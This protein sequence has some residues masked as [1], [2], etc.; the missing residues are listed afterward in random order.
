MVVRR[1]TLPG[2]DLLERRL[3]AGGLARS[4]QARDFPAIG[5]QHQRRPELHAERAP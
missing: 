4:Y 3:D 5:Q 2:I 1:L